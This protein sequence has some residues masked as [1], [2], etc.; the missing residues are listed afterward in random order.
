MEAAQVE[1]VMEESSD[2]RRL[3][4]PTVIV[5]LLVIAIAAA[6][7]FMR[8]GGDKGSGGD[9]AAM[10]AAGTSATGKD[11]DGETE[12]KAPVPVSVEAAK[13]TDISS[14][15]TATANLVA[16]QQVDLVA[17]SE[18]R[19]TG[20]SVE[21]GTTVGR[22]A[23]LA[24]LNRDDAQILYNKARVRAANARAAFDRASEL[25]ERGLLS[26]S[27]FDA[28]EME[29]RVADEELNEAEYRLS[30]TTI[31]A[32]FGGQIVSRHIVQGQHVRPGEKLFTIVDA[33]PLIARIY[34]PER[35]VVGLSEGQ[36]VRMNLR[37]AD[38]VVFAARIRQI[39]PVVDVATGTVKLTLEASKVP[40]AV[41][42]GAF[43]SVD[44]TRETRKAATVIPRDSVIRELDQAHVFVV[45]GD[46]ARRRDVVLGL[47][48]GANVEIVRGL[49]AGDRV[50]TAGQGS[51]KDGS[52]VKLLASAT[53]NHTA[54]APAR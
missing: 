7:F 3:I 9:K 24:S 54:P 12:E 28:R 2:R 36:K 10:A 37:A 34:L 22:G 16:E 35:D 48:E 46:V 53:R 8:N 21:E 14:Y 25:H 26:R 31:R 40:P 30:K 6:A 13:T 19:V 27:D 32:P 52:L 42:P 45:D 51:L 5:G 39:S 47:E 18:G 38:G 20:L 41:R 23:V 50:I 17:E 1:P 33:D 4:V 43:V 29:R 44:I 15:I 11:G 49:S